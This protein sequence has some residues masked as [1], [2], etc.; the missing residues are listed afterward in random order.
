MGY[1][2]EVYPRLER[3]AEYE[4]TQKYNADRGFS[5][6]D[7]K[8]RVVYF[9]EQFGLPYSRMR[10]LD[11]IKSNCFRDPMLRAGWQIKRKPLTQRF[12]DLPEGVYRALA[13]YLKTNSK[14]IFTEKNLSDIKILEGVADQPVAPD[15]L[16]FPLRSATIRGAIRLWEDCPWSDAMAVMSIAHSH[17]NAQTPVSEP[18]V[19]SSVGSNGRQLM[20]DQK[21]KDEQVQDY[22]VKFADEQP[23][24]RIPSVEEMAML[25]WMRGPVVCDEEDDDF[26]DTER[27]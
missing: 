5:G 21:F 13:E 6:S 14:D 11:S 3:E 24:F 8:N 20:E 22:R 26:S 10:E 25:G 9:C 4:R 2:F 23:V 15:C 18:Y 16:C 7:L 27:A 1:M 19:S 17:A 12:G